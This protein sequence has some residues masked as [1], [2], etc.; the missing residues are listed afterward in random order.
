[1]WTGRRGTVL[2]VP[3]ALLVGVDVVIGAAPALANWLPYVLN[4]VGAAVL[5]SGALPAT[6]PV[7]ATVGWTTA[8]ILAAVW[9]FK[10]LEL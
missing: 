4:R 8:L 5:V 9:R 1:V 7:L 10:R 3:L 2:A 6:G